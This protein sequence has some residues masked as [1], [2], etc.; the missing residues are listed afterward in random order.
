MQQVNGSQAPK[1]LRGAAIGDWVRNQQVKAY[2]NYKYHKQ[3]E[4]KL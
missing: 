3:G 4:T 2:Q 1:S